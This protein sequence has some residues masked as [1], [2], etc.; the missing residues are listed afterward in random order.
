MNENGRQAEEP[1]VQVSVNDLLLKIGSLTMELEY[2]K[3]QA[4]QA[5]AASPR[6]SEL[7]KKVE[8]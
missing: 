8:A 4:Q 1:R 5:Q 7:L 6:V 3:A 2:W